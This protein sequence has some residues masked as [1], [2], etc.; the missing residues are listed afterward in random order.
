MKFS[1][2][3]PVYNT[4]CY[5]K[6]CIDSVK[7]QTYTDFQVIL[8]NDGSTDR[9]LE[10]IQ[11][12]IERD[13]RFMVV[14][15]KN[16]GQFSARK[17]GIGE[18]KGEYYL[19][20]DSD[21]KINSS[22]LEVLNDE[23][24]KHTSADIIVYNASRKEGYEDPIYDYSIPLNSIRLYQG[25][26]KEF[27]Y[28]IIIRTHNLNSMCLKCFRNRL[29]EGES[30]EDNSVYNI[31]NGEDLLQLLPLITKA[32]QVI[33]INKAL[34]FYRANDSSASRKYSPTYFESR[35]IVYE[36]I[37]KYIGIW[38]LDYK[39][40]YVE[41]HT[42]I[43]NNICDAIYNIRFADRKSQLEKIQEILVSNWMYKVIDNADM[44][45]LNFANKMMVL[46]IKM[47]MPL[48]MIALLR[49]RSVVDV[50]YKSI[51]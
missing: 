44:Y 10:I 43:S 39:K 42:R 4:E 7:K 2:I 18:A 30:R 31:R 37:V 26:D 15:Q 11:E 20:L 27:L 51:K 41:F 9:S 19:F 8:I 22:L 25:K 17:R 1:I 23:I 46:M 16:G 34:Y 5:I 32:K 12:C 49:A 48:G 13:S 50:F 36:S 24:Q 14:S 33:C 6:G 45:K 21:D 29:F 3:I 28:S 40:Y 35:K 38:N 47:R